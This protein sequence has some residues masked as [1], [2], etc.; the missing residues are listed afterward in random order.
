[1]KC[2]TCANTGE[3][4]FAA[5]DMPF[6]YKGE[7]IT[8]VATGQCCSQ[9]EEM[10]L[11]NEEWKRVDAILNKFHQDINLR[12]AYP[13]YISTVRKKLHLNKKEAG[14][15]FGGSANTFSRYENGLLE[16][17]VSVVKLLKVLDRHP[18]LLSEVR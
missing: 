14:A 9:C 5:K 8:I 17:P 4:V 3:M 11:G 12:S 18:E 16:P 15:I 1:M 7:T 6:A 13:K 2:P 10:V